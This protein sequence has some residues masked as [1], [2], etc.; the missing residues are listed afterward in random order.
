M[1]NQINDYSLGLGCGGSGEGGR[2]SSMFST[3]RMTKFAVPDTAIY[4]LAS[5]FMSTP[6]LDF[7]SQNSLQVGLPL[8]H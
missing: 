3:Q 7:W 6:T 8:A 1:T 2:S 4:T 5:Q